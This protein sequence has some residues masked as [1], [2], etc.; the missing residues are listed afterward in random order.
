LAN[1]NTI[2]V[3][4]VQKKHDGAGNTVTGELDFPQQH[5]ADI[6]NVGVSA[7]GKFIMSCSNDTTIVIWNLKGSFTGYSYEQVSQKLVLSEC[8]HLYFIAIAFIAFTLHEIKPCLVFW[9][10]TRYRFI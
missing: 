4:K 8:N 6:I 2:R 5:K 10:D 7:S 3:F 1:G 9:E